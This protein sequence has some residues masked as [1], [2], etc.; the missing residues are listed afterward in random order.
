MSFKSAREQSGL[1]ITDVMKVLGVTDS[2]VYQW[3]SGYTKPDIDKLP[4][5]A[6]LYGCSIN[7]LLEGN[8]PCQRG[9]K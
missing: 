2:A 3:E 7:E 9:K 5:M 1:K 4:V 6:E 8:P